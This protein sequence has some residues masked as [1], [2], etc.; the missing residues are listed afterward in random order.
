MKNLFLTAALLGI[1]CA[2]GPNGTNQ[3]EDTHMDNSYLFLVGTYTEHPEDGIHLVRFSPEENLLETIHVA[4]DVENPSYVIGNAS[5]TLVFSVEETNGPDGG[6]VTSF[7]LDKNAGSLEKI[8][9]VFTQGDHPCHL[10]LDPSERF[11]VASNYSGGNVT[12]IPVDEEGNLSAQTQVIQHH[13]SS[14]NA[15]RQ[16]KPHVHSGV[17]HPLESKVFVADLGIDQII[18]YTLDG[19]TSPVVNTE[20]NISIS[21]EPG[22]GPRHIAF[23]EKGDRL[24]L[25]HEMTAEVGVYAYDNGQLSHLETQSLVPEGFEGKVGAAEVRITSDGNYLYASNR[26][27]ANDITVFKVD[28]ETGRLAKVQNISSGGMTPRNFAITGDGKYLIAA[29]QGSDD[30]VIFERDGEN[31]RLNIT[32]ISLS[33]KKPVYIHLLE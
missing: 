18:A 22:A 25:I 16:S 14:V 4:S 21:I 30:L 10:S 9:S 20:D 3:T 23:N 31:G 13:G 8:N 11:L 6:K 26:G 28:G 5:Q 2:C 15:N 17:F 19:G 1:F 29:N 32:D 24:Y 27:E 33:I 12:M 7:R